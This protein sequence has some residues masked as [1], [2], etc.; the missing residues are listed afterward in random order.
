MST[1]IGAKDGEIAE[2][3][4]FPGD[5]LRAKFI[6]EN[7]LE[8]VHQYSS[9]RNMFGYTGTYKGKKISVQGS[10]M[11]IPSLS[12]YANELIKFYGVKTIIRVGTAGGM[13]EDVKIGAVILGQGSTT[14]SA[15]TANTFG[16]GVY[17]AP[18]SD[19][20]LL[21]RAYHV[22]QEMDVPVR[23]G[24]IFAADRFYNDELDMKKLADYGCVATEMES[25]GLFLIGA[26]YGIKTL[27]IL[28]CSDNLVTGE[29]ASPHDRE[30]AFTD[31]MKVSLETGIRG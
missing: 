29:S 17:Y 6:A 18:L 3:V 20:E 7:F 23:V 13:R 28:T 1:H 26:K 8:D 15:V 21:D 22:A 27:S 31:M 24:N 16:A 4:L 11:G 12:I 25:A 30:Q 2:T 10:G 14:D 5:P 9:I 19:F